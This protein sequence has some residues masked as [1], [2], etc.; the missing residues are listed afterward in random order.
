MEVVSKNWG[1]LRDSGLSSGDFQMETLIPFFSG[2]WQSLGYFLLKLK[3]DCYCLI[4]VEA[5]DAGKCVAVLWSAPQQ[6]VI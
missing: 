5:R 4:L 2:T 6:Q 3:E 1:N